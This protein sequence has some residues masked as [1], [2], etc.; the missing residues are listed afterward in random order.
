MQF[1]NFKLKIVLLNNIYMYCQIILFGTI[2][3]IDIFIYGS[4][5]SDF[6]AQKNMFI[7]YC[8]IAAKKSNNCFCR[9]VFLLKKLV[10]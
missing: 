10:G 7:R 6:A 5:L 8:R 1:D 3:I 4:I 9:V 2:C